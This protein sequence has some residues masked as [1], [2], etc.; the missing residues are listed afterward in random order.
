MNNKWL[1]IS[2]PYYWFYDILVALDYFRD[3]NIKDRSLEP[4]MQI[5]KKKQ[6]KDGTWILKIGILE[7]F[8]FRWGRLEN[9]ADGIL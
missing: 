6:N 3:L 4:A 5:V 8:Y 9:Q 7:R 2:F 1:K